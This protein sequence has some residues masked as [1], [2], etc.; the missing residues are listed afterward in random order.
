[1]GCCGQVHWAVLCWAGL[2]PAEPGCADLRWERLIRDCIGLGRAEL[3]NCTQLNRPLR[4]E[5]TRGVPSATWADK[6]DK[7]APYMPILHKRCCF[8]T[9]N[10]IFGA[11]G[12]KNGAFG[13]ARLPAARSTQP[14]ELHCPD[15]AEN[16]VP[17]SFEKIFNPPGGLKTNLKKF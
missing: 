10:A 12:V 5:L 13:A 16:R 11:S 2:G 8:A 6:V 17:S 4:S 1:M 15:L 14:L 7:S 9:R 3:R